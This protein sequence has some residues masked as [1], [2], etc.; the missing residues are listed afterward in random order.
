M[1][2]GCNDLIFYLSAWVDLH[3]AF[4]SKISVG[5]SSTCISL[6]PRLCLQVGVVRSRWISWSSKPVAGRV[7][8]CGRV[9]FHPAPRISFC[10]TRGNFDTSSNANLYHTLYSSNFDTS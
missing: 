8:G 4:H 9:H 10:F 6:S 5:P 1:H 2:A 3:S 7:L